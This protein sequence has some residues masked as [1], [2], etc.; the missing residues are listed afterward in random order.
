M[1]FAAEQINEQQQGELIQRVCAPAAKLIGRPKVG[2]DIPSSSLM[3]GVRAL[4]RNPE[5]LARGDFLCMVHRMGLAWQNSILEYV[6]Q[7]P[8][9]DKQG[10]KMEFWATIQNISERPV[11]LIAAVRKRPIPV[12]FVGMVDGGYA[13]ADDLHRYESKTKVLDPGDICEL[14]ASRAVAMLRRYAFD[15]RPLV[16]QQTTSKEGSEFTC[17]EVAYRA[18]WQEEEELKDDFKVND[19][20][21]FSDKHPDKP[22]RKKSD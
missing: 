22:R 2:G 11:N 19:V 1:D 9:Y 21:I 5:M 13:E 3:S 20:S 7:S 15:C 17:R 10:A 4:L 6:N 18:Q 14:R 12:S 8:P 16:E